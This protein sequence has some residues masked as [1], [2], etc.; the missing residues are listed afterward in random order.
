MGSTGITASTGTGAS[1][2]PPAPPWSSRLKPLY[3]AARTVPLG[4]VDTLTERFT[5]RPAAAAAT[6]LIGIPLDGAA[7][8]GPQ[9]GDRRGPERDRD[10]KPV[11][12]YDEH[13]LVPFGEV[14]APLFRSGLA[15]LTSPCGLQQWR[16]QPAVV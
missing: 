9:F 14:R 8:D 11:S 5:S 1:C 3:R 16:G 10:A 13:H 6:A 4:Y 2:W 7:T 15:L 12:R